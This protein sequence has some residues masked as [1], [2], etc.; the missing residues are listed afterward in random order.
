VPKFLLA[1]SAK[2]KKTRIF[3]TSMANLKGVIEKRV[4]KDSEDTEYTVIT[5]QAPLKLATVRDLF[6]RPFKKLADAEEAVQSV[7]TVVLDPTKQ[8]GR[9]TITAA[10]E[11]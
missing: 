3:E 5:F 7:E 9:W 10:K 11:D 2:N 8:R 6:N 1:Q 4:E